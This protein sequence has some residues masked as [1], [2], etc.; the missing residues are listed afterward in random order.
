MK[1]QGLVTAASPAA[2]VKVETLPAGTKVGPM[3]SPAV[4]DAIMQAF[5]GVKPPPP[6]G[7][8]AAKAAQ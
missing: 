2:S 4:T 3:V 7:A 8:A 6:V 1:N 5:P